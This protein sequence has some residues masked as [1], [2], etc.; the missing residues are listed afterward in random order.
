MGQNREL[1]GQYVCASIG[2][3][4]CD[5]STPV[6]LTDNGNWR[7]GRY[8]GAYTV[9][10]G[11]V[12]FDGVGGLATWGPAALG[13]GTLTFVSGDDKV[14]WRKV[15][16][17]NAGLAPGVYY[18]ATAPGGCQTAQGIEIVSGGTWSW[19][20]S[21]GSY[22]V[23]GGRVIFHGPQL[24]GWG[25]AEIGDHRLIFHSREG[26]SE[27]SASAAIPV[28]HT[29]FDPN[30]FELSCPL[31]AFDRQRVM[32]TIEAALAPGATNLS[33]AAAHQQLADFCRKAG[34]VKRAEQER[35]KAQYWKNG[36]S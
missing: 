14:V 5:T 12:T 27:W 4:P 36:G 16:T 32:S 23:V 33:R 11:S 3:G 29:R 25:P 34:D 28:N 15:T 9:G 13:P 17:G 21:G 8:A 2:A 35:L 26:D 20:A 24:P 10:G 6:Q 7:W 1:A 30:T 31:T 22:S 19:G 18:C